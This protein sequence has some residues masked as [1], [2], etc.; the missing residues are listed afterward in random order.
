MELNN[1]PDIENALQRIEAW[2][3]HQ[4]IDRPP[5][6]FSEHN[7]DFSAS[8]IAAGRAWPDLRARWFDAEFQVDY[9]LDSIKGRRFYGETFPVFW[10]NLGPNV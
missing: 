1:K 5:V 8:H 7:A 2:F 10:P 9:F 4:M 3:A 6:R